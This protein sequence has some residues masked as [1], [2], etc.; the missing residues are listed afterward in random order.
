MQDRLIPEE[1]TKE[2]RT[3]VVGSAVVTYERTTSTMDIAKKIARTGF[4]N[5]TVIFTE[6]QTRGRGRSGNSWCCP[7]HKGLLFTLLLSH[8]I[9]HDHLCLL[10]GTM[11]ISITE[12][13]RET[14]QLP[15]EIKWPNDILI[16]GKR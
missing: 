7:R 8:N 3:K 14:L 5:G 9:Q 10:T 4:K 1:I 13:I 2:L 16:A 11:A 6:E 15:A 12:T